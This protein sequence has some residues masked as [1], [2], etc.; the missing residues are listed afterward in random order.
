[1]NE[2][3]ITQFDVIECALMLEI[4]GKCSCL[5]VTVTDLKRFKNACNC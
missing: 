1:M 5:F 4:R 3:E 2:G